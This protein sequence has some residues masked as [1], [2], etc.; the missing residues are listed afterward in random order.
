MTTG[1]VRHMAVVETQMRRIA[2]A[3]EAMVVRLD[4]IG[5]TRVYNRPEIYDEMKNRAKGEGEVNA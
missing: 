2:D 4:A 5:M 3:L 1:E